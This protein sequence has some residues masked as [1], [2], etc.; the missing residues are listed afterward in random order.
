MSA[1]HLIAAILAVA[2]TL[3]T[4]PIPLHAQGPTAEDVQRLSALAEIRASVIRAIGAE[5]QTVDVSLTGKT[6]TVTRINS[7]MNR[8][9]HAGRDNEAK[10]IAD[11]VSEAIRG[12][13]EFKNLIAIRVQYEI[14]STVLNRTSTLV[15]DRVEFRA[16]PNGVFQFHRT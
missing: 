3:L 13:P 15:V 12:K 9:T 2:S 11:I 6:I 1:R 7:N 4:S 5:A 16:D 14:H 10:A 8:S